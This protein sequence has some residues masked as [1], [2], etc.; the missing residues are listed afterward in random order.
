MELIGRCR[1]GERQALDELYQQY[2]P[3]LLRICKQYTKDD[4]VSED[5]LHD[6]FVVILTSL[7]KLKDD[8][9]LEAWMASIVSI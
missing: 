9:K 7:D 5:L 3:Q 4:G 2:R 1:A 8:D 6:A